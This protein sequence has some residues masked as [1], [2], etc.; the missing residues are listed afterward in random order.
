M[1]KISRELVLKKLAMAFPE[2][3]VAENALRVLDRL[4]N[5][6]EPAA[7][8]MVQLA[9]I[10][11]CGGELWR[12]RDLV[13]A[14]RDDFA[15]VVSMAQAPERFNYLRAKASKKKVLTADERTEMQRRDQWQWMEWLT[16]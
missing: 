4:R 7:V 1:A 5:L 6:A 9:I 10:K 3:V 15:D 14:A 8:D 11:L 13:Q 12:V 2:P 16:A